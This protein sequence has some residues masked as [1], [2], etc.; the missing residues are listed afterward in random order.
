MSDDYFLAPGYTTSG[1]ESIFSAE[2]TVS[3]ILE[4][5]AA[6]ALALAD[7]GIAAEEEATA[8]AAACSEPV[9]DPSAILSSTWEK[10]TP[11]LDLR[12]EIAGRVD[13]NSGRWF[14]HGATTQDAIDTGLMIQA[15]RG[16][17]NI[18]SDLVSVGRRLHQL[19]I[20]H[21]DQPHMARTFLQDAHATTFGLRTAGWLS[22]VL[23]HHDDLLRQM[24]AL[25]VQL[26]GS[27][28]SRVEYGEVASDVVSALGARLGLGTSD[29]IWHGDRTVVLSLAHSLQ[30]L[31]R[32]MAKI[33]TDVALLASSSIAEVQV[34]AG[35]SSSMPGKANPIDSIR[36]VAAATACTGA[37]AMLTAAPSHELDRGVGAWHVEWFAVPLVFRTTAA[38][39][40]AMRSCLVS[41][42]VDSKAMAAA[43]S[44]YGGMPAK[45]G[46]IESVLD[47]AARVLDL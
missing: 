12:V 47:R 1:M 27:S 35:G 11:L 44:T 4:F 36:A 41:L 8:L 45:S 24:S 20:E 7:A 46:T 38:S 37:V 3:S 19:T 18:V 21:R 22:T 33:A 16:L 10:G 25:P 15:R 40:E 23:D 17:E 28:G 2:A 29:V 6:L 43:T 9:P 26:G 34:R 32:T 13:E 31:S 14:H 39:V 5:E 42:V 30:R